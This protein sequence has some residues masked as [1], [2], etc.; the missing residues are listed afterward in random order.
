[1]FFDNSL[2]YRFVEA[3]RK[4]GITVPII[5][6]M[7]PIYSRR[8]LISIPMS[9]GVNIPK[10][11]REVMSKYENKEDVRK[12]GID[13]ATRQC[14]DLIKNKVPCIHFYK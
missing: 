14:E 3:A 4:I 8:H 13:H 5:P 7:K 12:A 9:F 10:E 2:Y 11:V 1:M 6:G